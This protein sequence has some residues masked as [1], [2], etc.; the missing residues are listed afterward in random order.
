MSPTFVHMHI[1]YSPNHSSPAEEE[2][3]GEISKTRVHFEYYEAG[4]YNVN[5]LLLPRK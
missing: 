4:F 5:L 1:M 2:A 3:I